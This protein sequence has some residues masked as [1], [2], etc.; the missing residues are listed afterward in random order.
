MVMFVLKKILASKQITEQEYV[1][2]EFRLRLDYARKTT[3]TAIDALEL[4]LHADNLSADDRAKIAE[5]LQKLK[6]DLAEEEA[7]AEIAAINSVTKADERAQ[8]E[9]Q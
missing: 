9:R 6:A 4:E 5:Q 3:E 8:K 2:E 7:E 1:A